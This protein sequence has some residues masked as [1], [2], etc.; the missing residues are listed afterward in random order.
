MSLLKK[1]SELEVH[2]TI[3]MLLYGQPGVC[4]TTLGLSAPKPVLVDFD[5]G[6]HRVNQAHQT[7]TL[8]V[9]SYDDFLALINSGELAPFETL[10][11]DTAGKMLDFMDAYIIRGNDKLRRY[12]GSLTLAGYGVRKSMFRDMLKTVSSFG[13][14]IVFIAH[15]KEDKDGD[16][17]IVR[18]DIGGSSAGDLIRELD[19][20]GYVEMK[21]NKRTISFN[22]CEKFYGKNTCN[23][24]PV[25]QIPVLL[26]SKGMPIANNDLLSQIFSKFK[27]SQLAKVKKGADYELLISSLELMASNADI[28]TLN[29]MLKEV[30]KMEHIWDSILRAKGIISARAKEINAIYSREEGKYISAIIE[31]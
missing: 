3:F 28:D 11:V 23:L 31:I 19:L 4:K 18:P 24:D 13:K 20:V 22:P 14:N 5:R 7:E 17:R 2:S 12:D 10:V 29:E 25:I 21:G 8:Q 26:D 15:E 16:T 1:P 30:P 9:T 6:V 27:D